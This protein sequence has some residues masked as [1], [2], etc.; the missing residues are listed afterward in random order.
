MVFWWGLPINV[1]TR[2]QKLQMTTNKQYMWI[3]II[4]TGLTCCNLK[5]YISNFEYMVTEE[6]N[7]FYLG[8]IY[9]R[10]IVLNFEI[11]MPRNF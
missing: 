10:L 8:Q 4:I 7:I 9:V 5:T 6:Y 2:T 3:F 11:Y 1:F